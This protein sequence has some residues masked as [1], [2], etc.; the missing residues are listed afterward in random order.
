MQMLL[1]VNKPHD[2]LPFLHLPLLHCLTWLQC[3][4]VSLFG[5]YVIVTPELKLSCWL[6]TAG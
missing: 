1:K 2:T 4:T 3:L 6:F 5:Y